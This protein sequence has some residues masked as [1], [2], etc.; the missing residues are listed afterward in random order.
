MH[1]HCYLTH[2]DGIFILLVKVNIV[3]IVKN[4]VCH[5]LE[6]F[7]CTKL[8]LPI[9]LLYWFCEKEG[10]KP[11]TV[12]FLFAKL[13]LIKMPLWPPFTASGEYIGLW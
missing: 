7:R 13:F 6:V 2:Y 12:S 4:N 8:N 9:G 11:S 5:L 10:T 3:N 1:D